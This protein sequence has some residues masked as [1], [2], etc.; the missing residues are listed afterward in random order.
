MSVVQGVDRKEPP[1]E[2][3]LVSAPARSTA[4]LSRSS[5]L[6]GSGLPPLTQ[7]T[8]QSGP[9]AAAV[10][11]GRRHVGDHRGCRPPCLPWAWPS[12]STFSCP[13][14][15]CPCS[16]CVDRVLLR[17]ERGGGTDLQKDRFPALRYSVH[18]HPLSPQNSGGSSTS[19]LLGSRGHP[20][21]PAATNGAWRRPSS[22]ACPA[23][24][25]S[26]LLLTENCSFGWAVPSASGPA[27]ER[28]R[29]PESW[30]H[31]PAKAQHASAR[32][33]RRLSTTSSYVLSLGNVA[34]VMSIG[35][36]AERL[37]AAL[38]ESIGRSGGSQQRSVPVTRRP[39][40]PFNE[41]SDPASGHLSAASE[42]PQRE[43]VRD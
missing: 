35:T 5:S 40:A 3:L 36:V 41:M 34:Y 23:T 42:P 13:G 1:N 26:Q 6:V 25:V 27:S 19:G 12:C 22:P 11:L 7:T 18:R 8:L 43:A 31:L 38:S 21:D 37:T 14:Q 29:Q 20:T 10:T 32:V 4:I 24:M 33:E 16:W 17:T 9:W 15:R 30:D 39:R 28:V 2:T